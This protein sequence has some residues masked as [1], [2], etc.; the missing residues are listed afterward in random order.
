[1]DDIMDKLFLDK[2]FVVTGQ[3]AKISREDITKF[4]ED[5]GGKVATAISSK[6]D[7]LIAGH[8]LEDGRDVKTSMKYQKATKIGVKI[9]TED[10]FEELVKRLSGYSTFTFGNRELV[11]EHI[12]QLDPTF[13]K[14]ES[15]DVK[16][17][18]KED[19]TGKDIRTEMWT[20][21]YKPN[22]IHDLVGN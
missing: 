3:F 22:N 6:T 9:L 11:L 21:I 15:P 14:K 18:I 8:T 10:G 12:K 16:K 19:A 1:M 13:N 17:E 7:Y 5:K 20:D 4:I 2:T